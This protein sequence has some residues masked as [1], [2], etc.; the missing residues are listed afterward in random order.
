MSET[1]EIYGVFDGQHMVSDGGKMYPVMPNYAS[2]TK[3]VEGDRLKL[4]IGEGG[5]HYKQVERVKTGIFIGMAKEVE[6][7]MMIEYNGKY[8]KAIQASLNYHDVKDGQELFIVLPLDR[9]A[10]WV[11]IEGVIG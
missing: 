2:T 9:D 11:A 3:L 6:G 7:R 1:K 5:M 4:V 8:Y 10:D